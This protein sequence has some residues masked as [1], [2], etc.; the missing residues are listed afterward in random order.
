MHLQKAEAMSA[1]IEE[2]LMLAHNEAV[3]T[4]LKW[5]L[6]NLNAM[7]RKIS[8]VWQ[9]IASKK[10]VQIEIQNRQTVWI[11]AERLLLE[12]LIVNFLDNAI[13]HTPAHGVITLTVGLQEKEACLIV[14]DTGNGIS[15]EELPH[16]FD[17]FFRK[18]SSKSEMPSTGLGLGLCRWI[19]EVHS[20]QIS[21]ASPP[22]QGAIFTVRFPSV[23]PP[24][25]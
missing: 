20:G 15:S 23:P 21:A 10:L 1:I 14:R 8:T 17:R 11:Q 7:V 25:G 18:K 13:K 22:G 9:E 19:V 2:L 12:R 3:E 16:I 5:E 24:V 6:V 4:A